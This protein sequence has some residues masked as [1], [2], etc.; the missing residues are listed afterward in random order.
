MRASMAVLK[1]GVLLAST[2][3]V[4]VT[5]LGCHSASATLPVGKSAS[6][7]VTEHR[8]AVKTVKVDPRMFGLH[9]AH[10]KSLKHRSTRAIR[11]WDTGT[12]WAEVQPTSGPPSYARL[13]KVVRAAHADHTEV[14]LV[15]AMTPGWA[16][17][18]RKHAAPTDMPKLPAFKRYLNAV[19]KHYKNFFGPGK[20]GI[21]N[22]QVWNEA[23]IST[24]WTGTQAQMGQLIRAAWQVRQQ[25]DRGAHLIGPSMVARLGYQQKWIHQF[26]KTKVGGKPVWKYVDGLGFSLYPVDTEPAGKGTR[27]ATPEDS[28]KLLRLVKGFLAKDKVS[29][30]MPLWNNEVN[31][32]LRAG[33]EAGKP[34]KPIPA[35]R[36]VAYVMRTYL[37]NAAAGVKRVFWYSYD[38]GSF[39]GGKTLGNT[40]LTNP[41]HPAAG[42][43]TPAGRAF[44]RIQTWMAGTLVGTR[45]NAPCAADRRGTYTCVV[46]YRKGVGRIYWNPRKTVTVTLVRSAT[47]RTTELGVTA[48]TK[49]GSRL[50]VDYRPVLVRSAH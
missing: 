21:A 29:P 37:L 36:Q 3:A 40:L 45:T 46:Q 9:D 25:I 42:T 39:A 15:V 20:R 19:M 12:T 13:N 22:Y 41:H 50:R 14:T 4:A 23:N 1:R 2:L 8:G 32:G 38:M 34:A 18:S 10:L 5:V 16:A 26:Y 44:T 24:F 33:S 30:R 7:G 6:A 28:I 11:L 31:Y 49:G 48:K 17:A 35:A 27:P 47:S 43:L